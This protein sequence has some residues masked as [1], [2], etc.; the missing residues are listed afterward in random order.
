M[1]EVIIKKSN[2]EEEIFDPEKLKRSLMRA[3][4][5][6]L[7]T[8]DIITKVEKKL[9]PGMTTEQV[10]KIAFAMLKKKEKPTAL[11]YSMRRS[12]LNLGPTGFPFERFVSRIF[13]K[14]GFKT[15]VG[16]VLQGHC[17]RHEVDVVAW[18]A[19]ELILIEV[20]FHNLQSIK[21]DTKVA[22]YV[23]A[24][25]DDLKTQEIN[26]GSDRHMKP[27]R[28]IIVTNTKFTHNAERYAKC[29]ELGMISW[30]YPE[31]GNLYDL[32]QQTDI[33]PVTVLT[34]LSKNQKRRL[35]D[36]DV[37]TC[38]Q[39]LSSPKLLNKFGLGHR[40]IADIL[41]EA[42]MICEKQ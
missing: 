21:T 9:R 1:K 38:G 26:L 3:S 32:I 39:L 15:M 34:G 11:R 28:G 7:V 19:R 10:Y 41:R 24:R 35:I 29:V 14:K 18:D 30:N 20:K 16:P 22:L 2:G 17:I 8:N 33:H 27:T 12:I 13:E 5:S 4:A 25:I 36:E 6:L 42:R 37:I 40:K 23:K 31:K